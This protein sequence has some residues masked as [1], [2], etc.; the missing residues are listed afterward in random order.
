MKRELVGMALILAIAGAAP[1]TPAPAQTV[2]TALALPPQEDDAYTRY[3]LLAPGSGRFRIVYD[4]TQRRSG[5]TVFFN[6]I[7][8]GSVASDESV[9]DLATGAPLTFSVVGGAEAKGPEFPD[10]DPT[11][12]YIRVELARPVPAD[13][14]EGR[15]RIEK[16]Y[17]DARSYHA[18]GTD[19]VFDRPLGVKRNAVVLPPGYALVACNYPSQ[20]AREPDGR[21][22]I[23]FLNDT[24]A[25]APLILRARPAT[26]GPPSPLA[27]VEERARQTRDIV[28]FL[29]PPETHAFSLYHDYTETRPGVARYINVV[30]TG[31]DVSDPSARDLDTGA[32]IPA[33]IL[34]GAE[35]TAAGVSDPEIPP[36]TP[37]TEIVVFAFPPI[38]PRHSLRL[39]MAETYADPK[40]YR[41]EG[42]SLYFD[43]TFG[44]PANAVVLPAGWRLTSSLS[45][46]VVSQTP[47]GRTRLDFINPRDDQLEVRFTAT[48]ET[49]P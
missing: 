21:L 18:D 39:R 45:P 14:G 26:L 28:Y 11:Y 29:H 33:H 3:E 30:R 5:A 46:A 40:G 24:P 43:R 13:G 20:V 17:E 42:D 35:I 32:A 23:S 47:D 27:A 48:R 16:T 34:K 6:P 41:V 10:A 1:A 36:I 19:I 25:E 2:V 7:R 9:T 38:Q 22:R 37:K 8:K 15:I 44:R 12:D 49:A 31:S 4:V